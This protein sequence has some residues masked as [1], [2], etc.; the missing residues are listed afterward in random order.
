MR[1]SMLFICFLLIAFTTKAGRIVTDSIKSQVL[2][3]TVK[4]NVF[5][6]SGFRDSNDHYPVVYLL[7]GLSDTYRAWEQKGGMGEITDDLIDSGEAMPMVIV[8]PNAGGRD[9]H[10][11]WDGYFNMAEWNYEDFFFNELIPQMESKYRC[12]GNKQQRAV[13]GLSINDNNNV[14]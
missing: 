3:A 2:G 14:V 4:I 12:G 8:M 13:M 11:I 7:H 5:L 6:P 1:K 9:V 10:N